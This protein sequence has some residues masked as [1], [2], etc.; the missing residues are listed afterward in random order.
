MGIRGASQSMIETHGFPAVAARGATTLL[1]G[2]LH[3]PL[4]PTATDSVGVARALL[5]GEGSQDDGRNAKF[6]TI[7]I[8]CPVEG[9]ASVEGT[10]GVR[11][12]GIES[13]DVELIE[14]QTRRGP[15]TTVNSTVQEVNVT[16]GTTFPG[17]LS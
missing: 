11:Q 10:V 5:H 13:H 9:L 12:R 4:L 2:D 17:D 15:S 3:E 6:A 8:E 16:V 7:L 1:L 14:G